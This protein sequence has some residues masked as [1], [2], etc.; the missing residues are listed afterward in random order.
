MTA[1]ET[2][3]RIIRDNKAGRPKGI[4]AVCSA[5]KGVIRA[6]MQQALADDSILLVESTSNQVDQFGGYTGMTPA[7]FVAYMQGIADDEDFPEERLLLGGD[8][9]GP[10][11]WQDRAA[12]EAMDNSH[13]LIRQ[14]VAAGYHKIHLDCSMFLTDDEGDRSK[15]LADEI[16]A[17]R[18]AALCTTAEETWKTFP[19]GAH[20]PVYVIGTDVPVPGGAREHAEVME[21]TPAADA[22]RTVEVTKR[23]FL[24]AG[25]KD[26]WER[27]CALVVQPGVEFGDDQVFD[28]DAVKADALIGALDGVPNLVFEAHSTDYQTEAALTAMTAG[29]FCVQKVGPWLTYAWREALFALADIETES[30]VADSSRLKEILEEVMQADPKYWKKYYSGTE[31]E[32]FIKRK[33]S[34]SDRSRYYWPDERLAAAVEKLFANLRAAK[35]SPTLYYQYMPAEYHAWRAGEVDLDPEAMA[36]RHVRGVLGVYSR[37]CRMGT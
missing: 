4:Y 8:H 16:V 37:A 34:Y 15:P 18:A 6:S 33:Y 36:L 32:Q 29:H 11:E 13:E 23:A 20:A 2:F 9:L 25:L 3:A 12:A 19:A 21:V 28:Y 17:A 27:V 22:Q 30:S 35:P 14:Y 26:A 7:D 31:Q 5:H 10:N 24:D 1:V